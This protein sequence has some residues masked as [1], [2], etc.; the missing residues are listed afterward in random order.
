MHARI[1][2]ARERT[3]SCTPR[4]RCVIS[5]AA[6]Q[7]STRWSHAACVGVTCGCTRGGRA[8]HR[9]ITAGVCVPSVS[10]MTCPSR[11]AGPWTARAVTKAR[12]ANRAMPPTNLTPPVSRLHFQCGTA[13]RRPVPVVVVGPPVSVAR[14]Q[15]EHRRRAIP[16]LDR[17][18]VVDAEARG[19]RRRIELHPHD[20]ADRVDAH[21]IRRPREGLRAMRLPSASLPEAM[22][23]HRTDARGRRQRARAPVGRAARC[24]FHR[25]S[26]DGFHRRLGDRPLKHGPV[27]RRGADA[28]RRRQSAALATPGA[29][30]STPRSGRLATAPRR[31]I[32]EAT[33][34]WIR[35]QTRADRVKRKHLNVEFDP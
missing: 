12:H 35:V 24:R 30:A 32:G 14:A 13:R 4:R 1:A 31:R 18:R 29:T 34:H 25:P 19:V 2:D 15:G 3:L 8:H 27:P 26:S 23:T 10:M 21:R 28:R 6:H 20:V 9:R 17:R 7:R 11:S 5:R 22:H 16:G 33:T